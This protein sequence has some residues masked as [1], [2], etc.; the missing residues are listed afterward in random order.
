MTLN[1]ETARLD[2]PAAVALT[3][4][5]V[6]EI[7]GRYGGE[8][9][10][11]GKPRADEFVAPDGTFLIARLAGAP[12]ACGGFSRLDAETAE[13]RRMYVAPEARGQ[14][15]SRALLHRLLAI[16]RDLGYSRAR[17]ETGNRQHEAIGLYE[18][19][20]FTRIP[21]WGPFVDDPKSVCF[22]LELVSRQHTRGYT[23]ARNGAK[24]APRR[25]R[26]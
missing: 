23:R 20:G 8:P 11:G 1:L 18:S 5:S 15:I 7:D 12:V 2:D 25:G 13:L 17:L 24:N 22:E 4:A 16:A 6:A 21:C 3:T 19:D 26:A 14:G 10:S 9:G